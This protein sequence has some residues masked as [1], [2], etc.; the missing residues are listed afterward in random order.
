[1]ASTEIIWRTRA[2]DLM[3]VIVDS[4]EADDDRV[5]VAIGR[6]SFLRLP[7]IE[8]R[9]L[10]RALIDAADTPAE[11]APAPRKVIPIQ[12]TPPPAALYHD[13]DHF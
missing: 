5:R 7:R 8:A 2:G 1:M 11:P 13:P 4:P 12:L 10:A 3:G 9:L 6:R